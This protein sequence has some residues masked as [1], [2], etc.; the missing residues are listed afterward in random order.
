MNE[1]DFASEDQSYRVAFVT[2]SGG[3][4]VVEEFDACD[5]DAAND[6]AAKHYGDREWFVLNADGKNINGDPQSPDPGPWK[7][8][9]DSTLP[10]RAAKH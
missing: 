10:P 5:D 3:F 6:Y 1:N 8:E 4:E 7:R 9:F 2:T